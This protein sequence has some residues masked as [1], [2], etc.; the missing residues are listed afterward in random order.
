M[1]LEVREACCRV[2]GAVFCS[3]TPEWRLRL[4]SAYRFAVPVAVLVSQQLALVVPSSRLRD[5][6]PVGIEPRREREAIPDA[7]RDARGEAVLAELLLRR[8]QSPAERAFRLPP[9]KESTGAVADDQ[10]RDARRDFGRSGLAGGSDGAAERS[11][12]FRNLGLLGFLE[13]VGAF[14]GVLT[15]EDAHHGERQIRLLERAFGIDAGPLECV[16]PSVELGAGAVAQ[17]CAAQGLGSHGVVLRVLVVS[18][19][20]VMGHN[21]DVLRHGDPR[22]S[23]LRRLVALVRESDRG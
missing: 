18:P 1:T 16:E 2:R 5:R 22:T 9:S 10:V 6:E 7:V 3:Q 17:V 21:R 15:L 19:I 12:Q 8:T 23:K 14:L 4:V 11:G 20:R 13:D